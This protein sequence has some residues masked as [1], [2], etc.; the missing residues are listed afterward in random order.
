MTDQCQLLLQAIL[1]NRA[2]DQLRLVYADW[3]E[4]HGE[5]ARAEFI[6]VQVE[7]GNEKRVTYKRKIEKKIKHMLRGAAPLRRLKWINDVLD[8]L[9]MGVSVDGWGFLIAPVSPNA[10]F[11]RGF[12]AE[13]T[14]SSADWLTHH[15][16]ILTEHP[17]EVVR[18][19]DFPEVECVAGRHAI[20]VWFKDFPKIAGNIRHRGD[21]RMY[22]KFSAAQE[23]FKLH[24]PRIEFLLPKYGESS[25]KAAY[26]V[27]SNIT[28][29]LP[30]AKGSS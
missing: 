20:K 11:R 29:N 28:S 4:E 6:R 8:G 14:C 3:L 23:I 21:A 1:D 18:L 15:A 10:R 22:L 5:E 26:E 30:S 13:I 9:R 25:L 24:W 16:E 7:L 27:W 17:V 12:I 19:L 2:D